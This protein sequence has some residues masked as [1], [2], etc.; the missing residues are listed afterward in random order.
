LTMLKMVHAS[1]LH[2]IWTLSRVSE[3]VVS[4]IGRT[5]YFLLDIPACILHSSG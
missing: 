2:L 4:E 1:C 5:F 3:I